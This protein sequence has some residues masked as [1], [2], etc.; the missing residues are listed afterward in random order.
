[1]DNINVTRGNLNQRS[2][3]NK[4]IL[5]NIKG[6]DEG[7]GQFCCHFSTRLQGFSQA[8][9]MSLDIGVEKMNYGHASGMGE[10]DG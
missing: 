9:L 3:T 6:L 2:R 5:G 7:G 10:M 8:V 1:M 4:A